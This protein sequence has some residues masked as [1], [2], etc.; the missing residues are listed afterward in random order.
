MYTQANMTLSTDQHVSLLY[1]EKC[2]IVSDK[3]ISVWTYLFKAL[4][5][6][7]DTGHDW[8]ISSIMEVRIM[9]ETVNM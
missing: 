6:W 2:T 1:L 5:Y 7:N 4:K 9:D 8:P 3:L